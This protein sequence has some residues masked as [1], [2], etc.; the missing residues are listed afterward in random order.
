MERRIVL[1]GLAWVSGDV[2]TSRPPRS[3]GVLLAACEHVLRHDV[4]DGAVQAKVRRL[5]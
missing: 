1:G 4:A 2:R 5:L 3:Y